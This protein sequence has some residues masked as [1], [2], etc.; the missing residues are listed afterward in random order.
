MNNYYS[1]CCDCGTRYRVVASENTEQLQCPTCGLTCTVA[2]LEQLSAELDRDQPCPITRI[3]I[4]QQIR[5][6]FNKGSSRLS[7]V[8]NQNR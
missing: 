3:E 6:L 1:N 2:E 4:D 5:G 7:A 8:D